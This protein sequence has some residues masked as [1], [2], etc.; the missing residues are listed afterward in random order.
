MRVSP[1]DA[2][3]SMLINC[4]NIDIYNYMYVCVGV[5]NIDGY[6]TKERKFLASKMKL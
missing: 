4:M 6:L 3:E 1:H 5:Y 2:E